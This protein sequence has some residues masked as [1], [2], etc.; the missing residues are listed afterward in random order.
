MAEQTTVAIINSSEEIIET[1]QL[2]L[3]EAGYHT[4]GAHVLDFKKG[5]RDFVAFCQEQNP[6]VI[7]FDIAPPYEENWKFLQ[8][9]RDTKEVEGR[10]LIMTT[11]NKVRLEQLVGPTDA[12]EIVGKPFDLDEIVRSVKTTLHR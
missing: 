8:L 11:T 9:L 2:L 10:T 7:L 12:L 5:K 3:D 6:Q 1:L 4:V